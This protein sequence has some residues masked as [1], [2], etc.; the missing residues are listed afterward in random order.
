M[1][2]ITR[3]C[4]KCNGELQIP[5]NLKV[6]ICMYCGESFALQEDK[7]IE[8]S[9]AEEQARR[10]EY[11]ESLKGITGLTEDY[12]KFLTEFTRT[13]YHTSFDRYEQTGASI[14][15]P[16]ERYA[17]LSDQTAETIAEEVAK[18]LIDSIENEIQGLKNSIKG[19]IKDRTMD[20]YRFFLTVY[21]VPMIR[22]LRY[23]ISEPLAESIM[24]Q[25][26]SRYPK[27]LF[28]KAE[29]EDLEAGFRRKGLCFIT[30]A[31]CE[32]LDKEDDCYELTALR[33]FRDHYMQQ[34]GEGQ[35]LVEEYY[36]IAPAIV[37]YI[38]MGSDRKEKYMGIWKEYLQPCIKNIETGNLKQC[39]EDYVQMVQKL[40]QEMPYQL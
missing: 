15:L 17:S 14:L 30:T 21:T 20:R 40:R 35:A 34:T 39:E 25:W 2:F 6:C 10:T 13:A 33:E 37:T 12:E 19:P 38:N 31:V 9:S 1:D 36:R 22:H 3:K 26:C 29:F 8:I 16:I 23:S 5:S 7:P 11:Q 28:K 27:L 18:R 24:T 4:P 32:T